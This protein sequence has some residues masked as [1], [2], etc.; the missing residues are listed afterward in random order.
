MNPC[1]WALLVPPPTA[2]SKPVP[3]PGLGRD[4]PRAGAGSNSSDAAAQMRRQLEPR[5]AGPGRRANGLDRGQAEPGLIPTQHGEPESPGAPPGSWHRDLRPGRGGRDPTVAGPTGSDRAEPRPGAG[6]GGPGP[7]LRPGPEA[8]FR[9]DWTLRLDPGPLSPG[10][11]LAAGPGAPRRHL[12]HHCHLTRDN[13]DD[14]DWPP[15]S[16]GAEGTT[17]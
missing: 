10:L 8:E 11:R 12:Y 5:A 4:R 17:R 7:P 13:H 15:L 9:A 6:A 16:D 14:D 3:S 2:S 1:F